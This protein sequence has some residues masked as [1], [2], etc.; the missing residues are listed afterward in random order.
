MVVMSR[1]PGMQTKRRTAVKL[2]NTLAV[3]C[4]LVSIGWCYA[5]RNRILASWT[6]ISG[7]TQ[8]ISTWHK[9][10]GGAD[11]SLGGSMKGL[12]IR[13]IPIAYDMDAAIEDAGNRM[14]DQGW[15]GVPFPTSDGELLDVEMARVYTKGK[16]VRVLYGYG[17]PGY[18]DDLLMD[19]ELDGSGLAFE[20]MSVEAIMEAFSQDLPGIPPPEGGRR[21]F[22]LVDS[23]GS[24]VVAYAMDSTQG[25][26]AYEAFISHLA[27]IGWKEIKMRTDDHVSLWTRDAHYCLAGWRDSGWDNQSYLTVVRHGN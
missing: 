5:I 25:L 11:W 16:K 6:M 20:K 24:G 15:Q 7:P 13:P 21:C 2:L 18:S 4:I 22:S 9:V 10:E 12:T 23:T 17:P 3:V 27:S 1:F 8:P 19:L 14:L 26:A